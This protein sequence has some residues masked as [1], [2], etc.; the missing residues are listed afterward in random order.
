[1]QRS[2]EIIIRFWDPWGAKNEQLKEESLV[3]NARFLL[4]NNRLYLCGRLEVY[5]IRLRRNMVIKGS[6]WLKR[7]IL[8]HIRCG[9]FDPSGTDNLS[10]LVSCLLWSDFGFLERW[11]KRFAFGWRLLAVTDTALVHRI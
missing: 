1:V 5:C 3:W 2:L 4:R 6:F 7:V 9:S 11:S 10:I 8:N